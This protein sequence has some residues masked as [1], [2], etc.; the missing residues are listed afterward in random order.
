MEYGVWLCMAQA[1]KMV[2]RFDAPQLIQYNFIKLI[3]DN[4]NTIKIWKKFVN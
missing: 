1:V 4:E 3:L 2:E